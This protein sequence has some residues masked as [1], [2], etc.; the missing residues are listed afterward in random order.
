[1]KLRVAQ[2]AK[3]I[4][5]GEKKR[6]EQEALNQ[7]VLIDSLSYEYRVVTPIQ[8]QGSALAL[9]V[10]LLLMP[11]EIWS[12]KKTFKRSWLSSQ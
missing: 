2:A 11:R 8:L 5:N 9:N 10:D 12:L 3:V 4:A 6:T 1:M 7:C